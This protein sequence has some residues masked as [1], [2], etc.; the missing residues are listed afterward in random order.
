M[1]GFLAED[2]VFFVGLGLGVDVVALGGV[3]AGGVAV[4]VKGEV[5]VHLADYGVVFGT[6]V[7][8]GHGRQLRGWDLACRVS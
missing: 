7:E 1:G 2:A 6:E 8:R 4:A 3:V 5:G